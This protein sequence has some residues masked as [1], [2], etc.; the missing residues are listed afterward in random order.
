MDGSALQV[1]TRESMADATLWR[2]R[3]TE[4]RGSAGS[5]RQHPEEALDVRVRAHI[6]VP[7]E[8]G[9]LARRAA[10]APE[11]PEERLDVRVGPYVP[12]VVEV[13]AARDVLHDDNH[14]RYLVQE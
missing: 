4:P 7:V 13:R 11:A 1:T 3:G 5:P 10:V 2:C 12:V 9:P 8:V 6:P 14:V